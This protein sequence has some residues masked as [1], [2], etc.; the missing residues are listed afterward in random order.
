[1]IK[2]N[3]KI[4]IFS[5]CFRDSIPYINCN[6]EN[7]W[8]NVYEWLDDTLRYLRKYKYLGYQIIIRPHPNSIDK[9]FESTKLSLLQKKY[10]ITIDSTFKV[11]EILK[12]EEDFIILTWFGNIF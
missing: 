11:D 1:M 12:S 2:Y 10:Q 5:H 7:T 9:E 3:K 4:I 8:R 6:P